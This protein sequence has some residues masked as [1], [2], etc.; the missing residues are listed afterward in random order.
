MTDNLSDLKLKMQQ[1]RE[2]NK[3][4]SVLTAEQVEQMQRLLEIEE[5]KM[6]LDGVKVNPSKDLKKVEKKAEKMLPMDFVLGT[7]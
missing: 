7:T 3:L 4:I 6:L 5:I 2:G 1:R